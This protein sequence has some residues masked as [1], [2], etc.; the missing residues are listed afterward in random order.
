[1]ANAPSHGLLAELCTLMQRSNEGQRAMHK[2]IESLAE[3][4]RMS[5]S[6]S[7]S[8]SEPL[9]ETRLQRLY[10]ERTRPAYGT[11]DAYLHLGKQI[12]E[13]GREQ[14]RVLDKIHEKAHHAVAWGGAPT[15]QGSESREG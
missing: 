10:A 7:T 4:W 9:L 13:Q 14:N 6:A 11:S 1:M 5:A 8:G 15:P 2:S 3:C 12:L